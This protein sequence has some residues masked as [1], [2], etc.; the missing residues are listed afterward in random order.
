MIKPWF[1]VDFP[2][3]QYND[4]YI[5]KQIDLA[6]SSTWLKM[7]LSHSSVTCSVKATGAAHVETYGS[8]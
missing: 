5:E 7:L 2:L 8:T 3:N 1:P 4:N 6:E